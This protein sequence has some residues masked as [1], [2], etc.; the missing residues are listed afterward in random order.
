MVPIVRWAVF[1]PP[2]RCVLP[3]EAGVKA[4]QQKRLADVPASRFISFASLG[5]LHANVQHHLCAEPQRCRSV[6]LQK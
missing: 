2:P 5:T 6:K 4:V 1:C 3:T